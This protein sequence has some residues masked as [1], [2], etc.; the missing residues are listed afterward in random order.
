[1]NLLSRF[2]LYFLGTI[3]L[4]ING[5]YCERFLNILAAN[6]I[7]FWNPNVKKGVF[8]ITVLRKD[9][10]KIRFLRK[11]IGVKIKIVKKNGFPL[12]I[13]KYKYRYGL[14]IGAILFIVSLNILQKGM[15]NI[16]VNG[17]EKIK[18][19]EIIEFL[20]NNNVNYGK[21][22]KNIDTDILKQKLLLSFDNIAW[23]SLNKQGSV[24]EVNITEF[25]SENTSKTPY[26]IVAECDGVIKHIK[27]STGSVNV[28]LGDTVV[29]NQVLVSGIINYGYGNS[30]VEPKG[31]ILAEI[32]ADKVIKIS[33]KQNNKIYTGSIKNNYSVEIM[34]LKI[35]LYIKNEKNKYETVNSVR[36]LNFFGG[37]IPIKIYNDKYVFFNETTFEIDSAVA[38]EMAYKSLVDEFNNIDA[39]NV[40]IQLYNFSEKDGY[41]IFEY[42]TACIKDIGVNKLIEFSL[43]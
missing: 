36:K 25:E 17:N 32:K 1:M 9:I 5:E 18:D 35:P 22:M 3:R 21:I 24:L 33:K 11:N 20:N 4:R 23:A 2:F 7:S 8:Y 28:K 38:Q 16:K 10:K 34:G 13:N 26:N 37:E 30:F 27:V 6:S 29:K 39:D 41:Y 40:N 12:I 15:W 42:R 19:I 43:N 14:I 31:K